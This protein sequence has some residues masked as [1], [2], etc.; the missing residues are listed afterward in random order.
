M[1]DSKERNVSGARPEQEN[2]PSRRRD[3]G[4]E[5]RLVQ[6]R[7]A[8]QKAAAL[9][10]SRRRW[11]GFLAVYAV[12]FL[13]LGAAG[14]YAL[15]RYAAAYE[16]SIPEHV[17]DKLMAETGE[18][19]W[20]AYARQGAQLT[21]SE[22]EN[23]DE[24]FSE[25]FNAVLRGKTFTYRKAAG[26]WSDDAPAYTVRAGGKDLC[27]VTLAPIG[28]N[29]AGFGRQLWQLGSIRPAFV[30]D[31]LESVAVEIDAPVGDTVYI[32]GLPV[33]E[34]YRIGEA[35]CPDLTEL[36]SRFAVQPH[37]DRYRVDAMYGAITVIDKNGTALAP[38]RDE[39][40]RTVRYTAP[41]DEFYSVT[42]R[43]PESVR[44]TVGGVEL[45]AADAVK[46]EAGILA[47]LEAYTGGQ[48][49]R[50]LTWHYEGL[51]TLPE[52]TARSADGQSLTPLM[53]EKGELLYFLPQDEALKAA[54]EPRVREFFD[55]YIN[56]SSKAYNDISY[57]ALLG[58]ILPGTE[59]YS[60]VHDSVA[61]MIWASATQVH[62]DEL[63]F[64]DFRSA[65]EN[66][67]TCTIRYKADFAATA[68]YES[69][70]YDLQNAYELAF[71]R[72][73]GVWYAAAMSVI[74]G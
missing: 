13:I 74:A 53:N 47:G 52:I 61:A 17:M 58:C 30:M 41:E 54:V 3:D 15:Y 21:V 26:A 43:A 36:E 4:Y 18:E 7:R 59:L 70:T 33:G 66:C 71:V 67:F 72:V 12:L 55:K 27:L 64:A 38:E 14:C 35:P 19:Q 73:D 46:A 65:G 1:A 23:A 32:N 8:A 68:W 11:R 57:Q 44:V 6:R 31:E 40:N 49:V 63:T 2:I 51:Y 16:A 10:R 24:L 60:Y 48:A 45:G 50:E 69:Y 5:E 9:R 42:V 56:Y 25:Y 62:Y 29:A 34:K 39:A 37:F 20:Y 22:F 28:R